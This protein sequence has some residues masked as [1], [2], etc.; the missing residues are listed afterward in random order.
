MDILS[1]KYLYVY[2]KILEERIKSFLDQEHF[3]FIPR[4]NAFWAHIYK[5]GK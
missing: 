2:E 3:Y 1:D 5:L 4:K